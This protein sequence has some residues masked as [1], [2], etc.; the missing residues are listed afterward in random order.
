MAGNDSAAQRECFNLV[1]P[2]DFN[3][4]V[5]SGIKIEKAKFVNKHRIN[6]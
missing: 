3:R 6:M 5:Q 4:Y 1:D 2:P